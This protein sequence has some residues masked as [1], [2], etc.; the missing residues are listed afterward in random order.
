MVFTDSMQIP[1]GA[2]H[3]FTA[4]KFMDFV[5]DPEIAAKITA[6]VQ[7]RA[8]GE[9]GARRARE[10]RPRARRER[11]HLPRPG[12]DAQL[13]DVLA[14]RTR[15]R[16]T[17]P[18]SARSAPSRNGPRGSPPVTLFQR[19]RGAPALPAARAGPAVAGVLLRWCRST[20]WG[21]SRSRRARSSRATSSPGTSRPT[22]TRSRNY[23]EQLIR[24]FLY[25]GAGDADRAADRLPARL[26]DRL[27]GRQVEDRAAA[28]RD[29]AVLRHLPGPHAVVGDDPRRRRPVVDSSRRSACWATTAACW[30]RP[31]R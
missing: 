5:Y 15:R 29:P 18:S 31:G 12:E 24:S 17:R 22:R 13:Q 16:S 10:E 27:P 14:R 28:A 6:Y 4:E 9:G 26:R 30:R 8:A 25:A 11:A 20:T 1:V 7:L 2:P 23:D 21:A 3:A 19:R